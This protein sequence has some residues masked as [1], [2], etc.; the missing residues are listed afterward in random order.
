M[1]GKATIHDVLQ[2]LKRC[3]RGSDEW[4]AAGALREALGTLKVSK[5]EH[6]HKKRET[7]GA[8]AKKNKS[9]QNKM[10]AKA[11]P[12]FTYLASRAAKEC[13]RLEKKRGHSKKPAKK[14]H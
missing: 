8:I 6:V 13:A 10:P 1:T 2:L 4:K 5:G 9:G 7:T 14:S 12:R 3:E 11:K